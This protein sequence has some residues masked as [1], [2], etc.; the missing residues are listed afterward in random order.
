MEFNS[1]TKDDPLIEAIKV[2]QELCE[3]EQAYITTVHSY[4]TDQSLH[5]Q[6]HKDLRRARAAAVSI[7]PTTT[8]AAKAVGI[9]IPELKG[10]LTGISLRV[11]TVDVSV[12]DFVAEVSKDTS[13]EEVNNALRAAGKTM[14]KNVLD[15]CDLP[16][17]SVDFIDCPISS[18]VD[19]AMTMVIDNRMVKVISWYD[20]EWAYSCRV[21]D[22]IDY[23]GERL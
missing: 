11:P 16:L 3:I 7:I 4:T 2:I 18:I 19:S 8:G 21:V 13:V 23:I 10:K 15:V 6:P 20:N 14:R 22:L 17:V 9:V 5:D 12:V 1:I